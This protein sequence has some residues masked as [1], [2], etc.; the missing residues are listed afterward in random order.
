MLNIKLKDAN[1]Y[2]FKKIK[3]YFLVTIVC[4]E[5]D[6][7]KGEF[8]FDLLFYEQHVLID[9]LSMVESAKGELYSSLNEGIKYFF[10]GYMVTD[11]SVS[12]YYV[13]YHDEDN[14]IHAIQV[15]I[16]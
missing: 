3:P 13:N 1:G 11:S 8:S 16:D 12:S 4:N 2:L 6:E 14:Y 9:F 10:A 7:I 15:V 5:N